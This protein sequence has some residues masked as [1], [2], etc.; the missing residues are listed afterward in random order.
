MAR[1][2][3]PVPP[4]AQSARRS[5]AKVV[6]KI[7]EALKLLPQSAVSGTLPAHCRRSSAKVVKEILEAMN[8]TSPST[9]HRGTDCR[10]S[11]STSRAEFVMARDGLVRHS[12]V[13][14]RQ[15][16]D[17]RRCAGLLCCLS[18]KFLS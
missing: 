17:Q 14:S 1:I 11:L 3:F 6:K 10:S 18:C 9:P 7:L 4:S 13:M 16:T 2:P 12:E 8:L 5:S 15:A